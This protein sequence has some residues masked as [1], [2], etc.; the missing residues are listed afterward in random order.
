MGLIITPLR[1]LALLEES[2]RHGGHPSSRHIGLSNDALMQRLYAGEGAQNGGIAYISTFQTRMDAARAASQAFKNMPVSIAE[3]IRSSEKTRQIRIDEEI[4]VRFAM[5]GGAKWFPSNH[6]A[7]I[8]FANE[9]QRKQGLFYV[10]T[11]Y[12][13]PPNMLRVTPLAGNIDGELKSGP[14]QPSR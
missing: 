1:A 13:L 5:G 9:E 4:N 14:S 6:V 10:K 2:E 11:F 12:P 7:L 3:A 8:L